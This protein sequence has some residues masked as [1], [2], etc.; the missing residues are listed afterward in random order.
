[1]MFDGHSLVPGGALESRSKILPV[2]VPAGA[3]IG[4]IFLPYVGYLAVFGAMAMT[5]LTF[6]PDSRERVA[7]GTFGV[8]AFLGTALVSYYEWVDYERK[9]NPTPKQKESPLPIPVPAATIVL[10]TETATGYKEKYL[11]IDNPPS[12]AFI[13]AVYRSQGAGMDGRIPGE[14]YFEGMFRDKADGWLSKLEE[15]GVIEKIW[16]HDTSPRRWT[17]ALSLNQVLQ[18]F[19]YETVDAAYVPPQPSPQAKTVR[20]QPPATPKAGA[21]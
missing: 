16:P 12:A 1:M 9:H 7:M 6:L 15:L 20:E 2:P 4:K 18:A 13:V 8:V 11:R 10:R 14:R 21:K 5:A 3:T 19:G 17:G